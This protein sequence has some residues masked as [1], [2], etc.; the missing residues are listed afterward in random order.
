MYSATR[1]TRRYYD[2]RGDGGGGGGGGGD[3][4]DESGREGGDG[5]GN[6]FIDTRNDMESTWG[7][8]GKNEEKR[9]GR[10]K[11]GSFFSSPVTAATAGVERAARCY[12]AA[13]DPSD[14]KWRSW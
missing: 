14:R 4:D 9:K 6:Q 8:V 2:L 11:R 12:N 1:G 5:G 13:A 3:D 7:K 10:K